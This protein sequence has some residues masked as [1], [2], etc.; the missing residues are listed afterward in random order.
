MIHSR[1]SIVNNHLTGTTQD[2]LNPKTWY[3]LYLLSI[4][5]TK[6]AE[7]NAL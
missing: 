6:E 7:P 5:K 2:K 3:S 1:K 4:R